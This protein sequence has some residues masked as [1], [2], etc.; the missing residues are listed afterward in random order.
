MSV[1]EL[2]CCCLLGLQAVTVVQRSLRTRS[3]GNVTLAWSPSLYE[4]VVPSRGILGGMSSL[5]TPVWRVTAELFCP[6]WG[7]SLSLSSCCSDL[8][9][10]FLHI[11]LCDREM[12][13]IPGE[14][15][16]YGLSLKTNDLCVMLVPAC[17]CMV[18]GWLQLQA[19]G[20][21]TDQRSFDSCCAAGG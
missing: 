16:G 18:S 19:W 5:H 21:H 6:E 15:R 17:L 9:T 14:T 12:E 4:A 2:L 8:G 11:K 13:P 1:L 3:W 20:W 10:L 7:N